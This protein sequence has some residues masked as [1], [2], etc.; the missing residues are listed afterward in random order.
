MVFWGQSWSAITSRVIG[1]GRR[2]SLIKKQFEEKAA[3]WMRT[4]FKQWIMFEEFTEQFKDRF[5]SQE[6]HKGLQRKSMG[7]RDYDSRGE[8]L[9][10]YV[11]QWYVKD[12]I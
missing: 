6:K 9:V 7:K 3:A 4:H 12:N 8:T 2:V 1:I 5:W 10:K 11:T